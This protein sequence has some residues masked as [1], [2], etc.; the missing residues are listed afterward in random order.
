[1]FPGILDETIHFMRQTD[2]KVWVLTGD[3]V[4]TAR[5]IAMSCK[6][7]EPHM[8]EIFIDGKSESELHAAFQAATSITNDKDASSLKYC[9]VTGDAMLIIA[10]NHAFEKE[11]ESNTHKIR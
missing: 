6:L 4:G 1:M 10:K 7:I 8:K 5:S 9:M 11:V 2:I 3:K